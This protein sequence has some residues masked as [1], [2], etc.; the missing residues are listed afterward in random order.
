MKNSN[1]IECNNNNIEKNIKD[2]YNLL[3]NKWNLWSHLPHDDDWSEKSYKK[4]YKFNYVEDVITI[5]NIIP[6][7]I[8][9]NSC[10][11]IMKENIFPMWED[12][13]NRQGGCFSYRVSNKFVYQTWKE[14]VYVLTGNT[15]SDNENFVLSVNGI[16]IS[17]KKHFCVIKIWM[18]TCDF[19][20]PQVITNQIKSLIPQSALF[21]IHV[22]EF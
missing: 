16:S 6:E 21:K 20:N 14:L 22:P 13:M 18:K 15:I 9:N 17:P 8:V 12:K 19:Q 5:I 3:E 4:I 1:K 11:F 7:I 2:T 10:L